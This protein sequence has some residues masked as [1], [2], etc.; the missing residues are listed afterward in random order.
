MNK[1]VLKGKTESNKPE[2]ICLDKQQTWNKFKMCMN[3]LN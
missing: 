2:E 3:V 1:Q